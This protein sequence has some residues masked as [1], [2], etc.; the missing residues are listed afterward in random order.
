MRY[1]E[2]WPRYAKL[3]DEMRIKPDRVHEFEGIV[4]SKMLPHKAQYQEIEAATGVPWFF[5][6]LTHMRESNQNFGT[7]LGNGQSLAHVTTIV[8]KGRGPFTGPDA[9]KRGAIDALELEGLTHVKDWRLEKILFYLEQ[10]NGWGYAML[11]PPRPSPYIF[12]GTTVQQIGKFVADHV[13][14]EVWDTQPGC[15]PVLQ[16]LAETDS[17]IKFVRET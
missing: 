10:F 15:A 11:H 13:F 17:S 7:Y 1:S 16:K 9:F 6:A 3:W 12:G 4:R 14:R 2:M 8:P 5:I